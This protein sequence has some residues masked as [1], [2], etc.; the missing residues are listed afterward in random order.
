MISACSGQARNLAGIAHQ[1]TSSQAP[2]TPIYSFARHQGALTSA[3]HSPEI[4]GVEPQ[5]M[6]GVDVSIE[7]NIANA[8]SPRLEPFP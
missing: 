7:A 1:V 3:N 8:F 5:G 4:P 2:S 6:L